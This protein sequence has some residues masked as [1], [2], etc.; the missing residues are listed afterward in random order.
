[1]QKPTYSFGRH[2]CSWID[3]DPRLDG[4]QCAACPGPNS[5][6]CEAHHRIVY[7]PTKDRSDDPATWVKAP[8]DTGEQTGAAS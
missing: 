3:G 6:W 8:A 2:R 5:P 1:M 4:Q 7:R